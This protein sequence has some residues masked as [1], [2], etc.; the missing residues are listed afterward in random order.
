MWLW[1]LD[2]FFSMYRGSIRGSQLR[3]HLDKD[4]GHSKERERACP[5]VRYLSYTTALLYRGT[6]VAGDVEV[7]QRYE[8]PC[9]VWLT[10]RE[11]QS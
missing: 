5:G 4:P 9:F 1:Q 6:R 7:S 10:R 3:G 8:P 11:N 2:G